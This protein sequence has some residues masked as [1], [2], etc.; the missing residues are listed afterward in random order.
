MDQFNETRHEY[1]LWPCLMIETFGADQVP[2]VSATVLFLY[3]VKGH[4]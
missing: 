4:Q 1:S 3:F 2:V